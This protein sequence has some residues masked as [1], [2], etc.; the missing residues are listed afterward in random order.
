MRPN[1]Q[2]SGWQ[3]ALTS[4][5]NVATKENKRS[6]RGLIEELEAR[7]HNGPPILTAEIASAN[8]FLRQCSFS[9]DSDYFSRLMSIEN[10]LAGR[11]AAPAP[12]VSSKRNY[13]GKAGDRWVQVQ[14][15]HDH[16]IFSTCFEGEL[17]CKRGRIK[18]SHRF[19]GEGRIDFVELKFLRSLMPCLSGEIRKLILIKDYQTI[20]K[21]WLEGEAFVLSVLPQELL[22]LFEDLFRCEKNEVFAWLINIGHGMVADM[23]ADFG[24][25]NSKSIASETAETS[26]QLCVSELKH[27]DVA[28]P[29]LRKASVLQSVVELTNNKSAV[30][31]YHRV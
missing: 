14:S 13:G 4:R 18:L 7:V 24:A 19:N 22:F 16:V 12:R 6:A 31:R 10:R 9:P 29:V 5:Q 25:W 28:M 30:V 2:L 8:D 17:N 23:F 1:A 15:V 3:T 11:A 20:R 21:G 26:A 27:D